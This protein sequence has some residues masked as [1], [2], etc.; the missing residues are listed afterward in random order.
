MRLICLVHSAPP[1]TAAAGAGEG[2]AVAGA[3]T[4]PA[5]RVGR[6]RRAG[7]ALHG[8]AVS[9][10]RFRAIL[11]CR[12]IVKAFSPLAHD[13]PSNKPFQRAQGTVIL[14]SDKADRVT[15]RVGAASAAN[16]VDIILR[17]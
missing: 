5:R 12:R 2:R 3:R 15:H 8:T 10:L 9:L 16:A 6:L 14:R 4:T 7:M 11:A 13:S 1:A 17:V